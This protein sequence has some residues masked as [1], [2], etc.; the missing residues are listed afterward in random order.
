MATNFQFKKISVG[1]DYI[2]DHYTDALCLNDIANQ[3]HLSLYHF[4][5]VFKK[6]FGETPHAFLMRLRMEKAKT[7]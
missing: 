7:M 4:S 6:T 3:S 5:R 1:R 2:A